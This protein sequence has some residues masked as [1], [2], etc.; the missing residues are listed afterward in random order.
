[1]HAIAALQLLEESLPQ[2]G[3]E[4][5]SSP[6]ALIIIEKFSSLLIAQQTPYSF[7]SLV[8]TLATTSSNVN[9]AVTSHLNTSNF[10]EMDLFAHL[11][12]VAESKLAFTIWILANG[13]ET[14]VNT[15]KQNQA[16][17]VD[18]IKKQMHRVL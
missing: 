8:T 14:A 16:S 11:K 7:Q 5:E 13:K 15:A 9:N 10:V 3:L 12:H 4:Q 18:A 2:A 1:M 17:I 6:P